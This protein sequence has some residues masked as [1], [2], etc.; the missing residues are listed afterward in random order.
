M[1]VCVFIYVYVCMCMNECMS[2]ISE[3]SRCNILLDI[4]VNSQVYLKYLGVI[5]Y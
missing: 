1:Y 3:I 5:F 4:H 2:G